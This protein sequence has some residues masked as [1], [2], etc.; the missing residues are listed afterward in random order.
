MNHR[1][2][3]SI[4]GIYLITNT[5]NGK[6][7]VGQARNVGAR[8]S[9]HRHLLIKGTHN[10]PYL[11]RA[12]SKLGADAFQFTIAVDLSSV[13]KTQ[14]RA[15]Q[16]RHEALVFA[17][18]ADTYNLMHPGLNG[19][20]AQPETLDKLSARKKEFWV[21]LREDP[22]KMADMIY[23]ANEFRRSPE[24]RALSAAWANER[25]ANPEFREAVSK[26]NKAKWHRP[27]YR[28]NHQ[29]YLKS[30]WED[31]EKRDQRV[32]GLKTAWADP[33]IRA[34]RL[35]AIKVGQAKAME[36]PN[37]PM[38]QRGKKRWASESE[39][40]RQSEAY[41]AAWADPEFKAK[42]REALKAGWAKRKARLAASGTLPLPPE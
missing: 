3:T 36:D 2:P 22:E 15:E 6:V 9:H 8:W 39:R 13:P 24:G 38:H 5:T 21:N 1:K 37:S 16:N 28:E 19:H 10:N 23:R 11:Q 33:D 30:V 12:W 7:Y 27:G 31:P 42:R 18:L 41:T 40:K 14:L 17:T 32:M 34:K 20:V 25:W 29:A 4:P 26:G 35:E